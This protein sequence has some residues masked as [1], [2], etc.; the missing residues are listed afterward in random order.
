[1]V[2]V[3]P[4]IIIGTYVSEPWDSLVDRLC[5]LEQDVCSLDLRK[6]S[7]LAGWKLLDLKLCG[8]QNLISCFFDNT[9]IV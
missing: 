7:V 1:M 5:S 8:K 2:W 3:G 9:H 6:L 4:L